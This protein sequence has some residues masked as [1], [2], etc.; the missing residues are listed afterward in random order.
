MPLGREEKGYI[1]ALTGFLSCNTIFYASFTCTLHRIVGYGSDSSAEHTC[2]LS[3][4]DLPSDS[5][6]KGLALFCKPVTLYHII[7]ERAKQNVIFILKLEL[8]LLT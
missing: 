6:E 7:Q 1:Q 4:D 8:Y 2:Q 3:S 5:A